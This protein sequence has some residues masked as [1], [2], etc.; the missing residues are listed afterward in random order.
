MR[1]KHPDYVFTY[2][3]KPIETMNNPGWQHVL[4]NALVWSM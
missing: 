1:G 3:E 2:R 4:E